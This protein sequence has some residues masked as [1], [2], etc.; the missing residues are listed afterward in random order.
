MK[1][2]AS[3]YYL[4]FLIDL[5][6]VNSLKRTYIYNMIN[7]FCMVLEANL[8]SKEPFGLGTNHRAQHFGNHFKLSAWFE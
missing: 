5:D 3:S 2:H 1:I 6:S 8:K 7:A 4:S